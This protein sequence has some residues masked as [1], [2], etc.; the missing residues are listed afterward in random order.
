METYPMLTNWKNTAKI[1]ATQAFYIQCSSI[2][3]AMTFF[4]G[5]E[6][7]ILKFVQNH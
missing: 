5:K 3:G 7:K 6:N 4:R 1:R 2:K